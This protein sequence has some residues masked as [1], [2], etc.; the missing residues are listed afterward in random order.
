ML[1]SVLMALLFISA[2]NQLENKVQPSWLENSKAKMAKALLE[3]YGDAQKDRI[4]TGLKQ[5]AD[6]WRLEDGDAAVFEEFVEKN[7]AGDQKSIDVMFTRFQDNLEQLD[8]HMLE[9]L[10]KFRW[11]TDLD[12]GPIQ[13]FDELFAAYS[14]SDHVQ[15]DFFK[16]KLAFVVL[17]NFPLTTLD[18]RLN[19]GA[20]WSRRQW[21]EA[22]LA[23]RFGERVPADV[24]RTISEA[25]ALADQ[26]IAQ[27]NIW[28]HHLL[29]KDGNRYSRRACVYFH[30]GI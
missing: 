26:Y 16:N 7:F 12:L 5:V 9:I 15:D 4:V 2:T 3:K 27:Y 17:L 14:P 11:Q 18:Q 23:Q 13:P 30:T 10:L 22:R 6:F 8:G 24:N 21:A 20:N 25:S 1:L 28:M 19:D 29:D